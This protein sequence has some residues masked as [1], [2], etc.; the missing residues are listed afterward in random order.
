MVR[1]ILV[2][3]TNLGKRREILSILAGYDVEIVFPEEDLK[4]EEGGC[5]FLEN[6]YL[7]AKAYYE[8]YKM[9]TLAE[10]SG[11]VVTALEGYPGVYSSR[12]YEMEW[13]GREEPKESKDKANINK[14][15]RL[16]EGKQDRRA[17]YVAFA[18]LFVED[19]GLW[20]EG[21]CYGTILH[22]PVGE[23]GFGYDPIFQPEGY[24]RSMAE[25]SLEEKNLISHRGK[26]LR[27]VIQM[28]K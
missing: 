10:D 27:R 21:R 11:L 20:S 3:T 12:F 25:L 28:L 16:M 4:L 7:K 19:G 9:P 8:A 22:Q 23:G 13:G 14:V 1:K 2:A 26:A 17:Y 15:L 6:A 5:S 24:Q 18:V